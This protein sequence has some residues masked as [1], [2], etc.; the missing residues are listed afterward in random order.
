MWPY[1]SAHLHTGVAMRTKDVIA[2]KLQI[3]SRRTTPDPGMDTSIDLFHR[4]DILRGYGHAP[5]VVTLEHDD[6]HE[7]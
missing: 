2:N 3:P 5:E 7:A 1:F 4:F 6:R